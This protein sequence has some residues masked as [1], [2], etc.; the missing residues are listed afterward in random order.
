MKMNCI[1]VDDEPLALELLEDNI[2]RISYLQLQA[3]CRN[4]MD[5]IAVMQQHPADL[6][7]SD[8][9]MPGL[10]GLDFIRSLKSRPMFILITAYEQY[11]L[12]GFNVDVVDYLLKPIAYDRFLQA[13]N[14]AFELFSLKQRASRL[15]QPATD[16]EYIFLPVDYKMLKVEL[17]DIAYIEGVKDYIKF[18]FRDRTRKTL[19]VRMSM[20]MVQDILPESKFVRFHKSYIAQLRCITAVRRNSLFI[21]ELELPVGEQ[22]KEVVSRITGN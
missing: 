19:L 12:E 10:N 5:A 9:Q 6:V 7:F 15:P 13:C 22:Y 3:S 17:G 14:K 4:A 1:I 18:H 2:S 16:K 8:I 20:K 21:N 11:A